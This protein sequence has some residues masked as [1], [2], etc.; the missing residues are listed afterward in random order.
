MPEDLGDSP[1]NYHNALVDFRSA[2]RKAVLEELLAALRGKPAD[3][4]SYDEVRQKIRTITSATQKLETIPLDKIVGSVNRYTDFS[5]SFLPRNPADRDRWAH[6]RAGLEKSAGLP[7]IE[8]Y[9][10]GDVYFVLDGHHRVSVAREMGT[11]SI[12]AYVTPVYT[13]VPLSPDDSPDDLIIKSEYDD[14]LHAT[15]LDVLRPGADLLVTAPGMYPQLLEHISVHRYFMGQERGRDVP[16]AEAV[17][18]W[19][20]RVYQ[21]IANLIAG[22]NL[23]SDF[24]GRT[25]TDLYLWIMDHRVELSGSRAIGWEVSPERAAED[26]AR[27]Y[28]AAP[29]RRISRI[30]HA[31]AGRLTPQELEPGPPPGAWRSERQSPHRVDHLFDEILVALPESAGRSINQAVAL[32]RIETARLTGLHAVR[33]DSDRNA[34]AVQRIQDEFLRACEQ[35]QVTGRFLVE[36]GQAAELLIQRSRWVDLVVFRLR[37]PPPARVFQRLRSGTRLLIRRSAAPLLAV[38]DSSLPPRFERA[39]LAYGP[40]PKADEALYLAA[41][42]A[43]HLSLS[44]TV[45]SAEASLS[46]TLLERARSYLEAHGVQASYQEVRDRNARDVARELLLYAEGTQANLIIMGGYEAGPLRESLLGSTVDWVLRSSRLPV[47]IC[48]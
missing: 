31:L 29:R 10:V 6:V 36:T 23:L 1:L 34:D 12:E 2:R 18:D 40:G 16:Y 14:F 21:P 32:A 46:P 4:L 11:P 47:L 38:P 42:L 24:P 8:V 35:A 22:R 33:R 15:R 26:L 13:S 3:L 41:Y 48:Q 30:L 27:R 20:D 28:S 37:F 5:R 9:Q 39:M 17:T 19:Y 44:L 7:P 45:V 25:V 43:G